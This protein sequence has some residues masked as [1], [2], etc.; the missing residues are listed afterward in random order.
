MKLATTTH[1]I[2]V[3]LDTAPCEQPAS[4]PGKYLRRQRFGKEVC[5]IV[6]ATD[7]GNSDVVNFHLFS[8]TDMPPVN[9]FGALMVLRIVREVDGAFNVQVD[10]R[11]LAPL[12]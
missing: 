8:S 11:G 9:V 4:S 6:S 10:R 12:R 1:S 2:A 3:C 7:E 5:H